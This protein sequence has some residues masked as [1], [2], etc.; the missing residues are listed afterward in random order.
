MCAFLSKYFQV[1][2]LL[3]ISLKGYIN[4]GKIDWSISLHDDPYEYKATLYPFDVGVEPGIV[5]VPVKW[6]MLNAAIGNLGYSS[7]K[8]ESESG[9]EF[10]T[11]KTF[12]FQFDLATL[13]FGIHFII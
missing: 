9:E 10:S 11:T 1:N 4:Y 3:S 13:N 7:I 2:D 8:G 12:D 5:F 6:L